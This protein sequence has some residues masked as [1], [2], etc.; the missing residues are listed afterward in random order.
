VR[1]RIDLSTLNQSDWHEIVI[2]FIGGGL[3][4]AAIGVIAREWGPVVGGLFLAFPSIF[5]AASSLV[6]RHAKD[7]RSHTGA[8]GVSRAR[9]VAA[10]DAAGATIGSVGLLAFAI[11]AWQ[12]L[13]RL[14]AIAVLALATT[15]WFAVATLIWWTRKYI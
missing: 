15:A 7:K 11:V 8:D 13:P 6:E 3:I 9:H 10:L 4:T 5:P 12:L 14:N 1:V 2:R